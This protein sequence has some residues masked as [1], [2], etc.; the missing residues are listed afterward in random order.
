VIVDLERFVAEGRTHWSRLE[1]LLSEL[2]NSPDRRLDLDRV[3]ELHYLY[4]R[5]SS[6]L[7][8]IATSS[9]ERE[10]RRYL[11][12][13]VAR[14]YGEIYEVR[15]KS[16]RIHPLAWFT[17]TFPRTF[18]RHA[19]AFAV[20]AIVT[21]A[22]IGFGGLAVSFD[23]DAKEVIVPFGHLQDNPAERVAREE[24]ARED[25]LQGRKAAFSSQL[26]THNIRISIFAMALGITWGL[27]TA[28]LL[29]YNGAVLGAVAV[30]YVGAGKAA[31]LVGWLLPHGAVEIPAILIAGQAGLVLAGA[32][33]GLGDDAP[34]RSRLRRVMGPV[35][36]LMAGVGILLV[37]A[38]VIE[39]FFSQYHEPVLPYGLK[40]A[41]GIAELGLLAFFLGFSGK[42]EKG[43]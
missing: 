43:E 18:R 5:A 41:F 39:S 4:Q 2:A 33:I 21:L 32:L 11:E 37:W 6:D 10:T 3:R 22:G 17:R 23:P 34:F 1:N 13:L 14:A 42:R 8:R 27:G 25:H 15:S 36:T 19:A 7:T 28:L 31:F 30:D 12:S 9:F 16:T 40:I 20:S 38:G 29:F 35:V 26:M 24:A